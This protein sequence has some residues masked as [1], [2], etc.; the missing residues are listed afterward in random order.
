ML[1]ITNNVLD[2]SKLDRHAEAACC[3]ISLD[4]K[5]VCESILLL[6]INRDDADELDLMVVVSPDVP[7][8]LF[9]DDTFIHR[10]FINLI[11]NAL[12]FT[13]SGYILLLVEMN[14]DKL[15]TMVK[16]TGL[17]I[18]SSFLPRIFE[19]FTQVQVR[20]WQRGTG[21]GLSIIKQLL[22]KM[23]ETIAIE[24]LHSDTAEVCSEETGSTFAV[25]IL[26]P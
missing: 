14:D 12:K 11:S 15:V 20:G 19:P 26:M 2:W 16:D 4:M 3:P 9:L 7:H 21:L 18:P 8:S 23:Q 6:L 13:R 10:I 5:I 22:E 1:T 25:T 24:S 17:G